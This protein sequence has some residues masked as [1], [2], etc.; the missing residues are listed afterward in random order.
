MNQIIYAVYDNVSTGYEFRRDVL[1]RT[2]CKV[3][4]KRIRP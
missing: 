2:D 4:Q 1:I 3:C